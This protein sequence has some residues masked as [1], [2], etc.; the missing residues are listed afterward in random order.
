M[1]VRGRMMTSDE[2]FRLPRGRGYRYEL[3]KGELRQMTPAGF[4]H[5]VVIMNLAAPLSQFV[6][7]QNLGVVCGAETGFKLERDP[8]TVRAPDMAFV[9]RDRL[10]TSGRP[11]G[12]WEGAPD[13]AVEVLSPGDSVV[14]VEQNVSSWLTAGATAV[15]VVNPKNRTVTIS[16][17]GTAPR[18]LSERDSFDGEDVV[19]GFR[20]QVG[21][22]FAS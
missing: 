2:L 14:E 5:G 1:S 6:R 11:I 21:D 12:F 19:P 8:D 17:L 13:L 10:P 3:V 22:I 18:T 7:R 16:R 4:D 20:L 9:R 15:W